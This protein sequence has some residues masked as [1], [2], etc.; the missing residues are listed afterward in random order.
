MYNSLGAEFHYKQTLQNQ[1]CENHKYNMVYLS[2]GFIL[3]IKQ[4]KHL[5]E[6]FS[7]SFHTNFAAKTQVLAT[8]KKFS[9]SKSIPALV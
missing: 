6:L 7:T 4:K 1:A 8:L 2:S 5:T 9:K 3:I